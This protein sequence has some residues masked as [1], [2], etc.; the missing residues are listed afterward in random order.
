V[1]GNWGVSY[2]L[3]ADQQTDS[4]RAEW[5]LANY[6]DVLGVRPLLGRTFLPAEDDPATPG[7]AVV[8]SHQLWTRRFHAN[9][10]I[11]GSEIRLA[12][13]GQSEHPYTI[14]GVAPEGFRGITT[15]WQPSQLWVTFAQSGH[16]LTARRTV[17]GRPLY[18]MA[19]MGR[20][21]DGVSVEQARAVVQTQG[22]QLEGWP[23]APSGTTS[24]T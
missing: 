18:A 17:K 5:V 7:R 14:V 21:R 22:I 20:L 19:A 11:V 1:T 9:P 10:R 13:W 16:E 15:P 4:I 23:L 6:F 24:S 8:L 3:R 2:T 12:L